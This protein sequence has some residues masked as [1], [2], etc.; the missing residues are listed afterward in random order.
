M[1]IPKSIEI[2]DFL[3]FD[4]AV[5]EFKNNET[6]C[7]MGRNLT[8]DNQESNGSGKSALQAA[9]EFIYTGNVSRKVTK[10][11]LI[12]RGADKATIIHEA[13]NAVKNET[14]RIERTIPAKGSEKIKVF[15]NNQQVD[16][17]TTKDANDWIVDYIGIS[18][19]DISNYFIPNEVNYTSFFNSPDTK[20]NCLLY[21]SD[22]ADE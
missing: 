2:K 9:I 13:F 7:I 1:I 14:L 18:K 21:T 11:K 3:S 17:A 5:V 12:R 15:I 20:K 4:H 10:N 16:I 8:E 19:E 6:T 22:A